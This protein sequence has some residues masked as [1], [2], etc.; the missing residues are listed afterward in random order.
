[1]LYRELLRAMVLLSAAVAT[2][3]GVLS[4]LLVQGEPSTAAIVVGAGWWALA[5]V[6]GLVLGS[7]GRAARA[8]GPAL[9]AARTTT[10]LPADPPARVAFR[11]LWPIPAFAVACAVAGAFAPQVTAIGA[12]YAIL[13]ALLWRHRGDAVRAI[14]D[15]D[16]VR[17]YVE[18]GSALEPVRLV[19]TPGLYRGRPPAPKP[20]PPPPAPVG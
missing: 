2:A 19:R 14:E 3:L 18:P 9:A 10:S 4:V 17:F 11:R 8:M 20:P 15:R 5:T 13:T 7:S 6:A 12:G 16:G 1:M